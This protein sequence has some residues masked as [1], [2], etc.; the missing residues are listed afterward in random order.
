MDEREEVNDAAAAEDEIFIWA[1]AK[2]PL[3]LP[4]SPKTFEDLAGAVGFCLGPL[5]Q[6]ASVSDPHLPVICA[7]C[8]FGALEAVVKATEVIGA[9]ALPQ[10][11]GCKVIQ[12]AC[13]AIKRLSPPPPPN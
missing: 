3:P 10:I 5:S 7:P 11:F 12:S 13:F 2:P 4:V 8:D 6:V 9:A 1:I